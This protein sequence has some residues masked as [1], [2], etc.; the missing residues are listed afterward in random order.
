MGVKKS[1]MIKKKEQKSYLNLDEL[2]A[3]V[4]M[5]NSLAF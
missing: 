2:E 4:D 3:V 5:N 1:K